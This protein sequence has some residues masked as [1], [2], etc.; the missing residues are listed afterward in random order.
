MIAKL[1]PLLFFFILT[2]LSFIGYGQDFNLGRDW[3]SMGPNE[4]PEGRISA[5]GIGP[6][7]FIRISTLSPNKMLAGSLMGGLFIS[8]NGGDDWRNSGSD[9]WLSSGCAWAEFHPKNSNIWFAVSIRDDANGAP[10]SIGKNGGVMRTRDN[11]VTWEKVANYHDFDKGSYVTIYGLRFH[12][13][14]VN[15]LYVHTSDGLYFTE[16]CT[17]DD[18]AWTKVNYLEGSIYD[19]AVSPKYICFSIARKNIWQVIVSDEQVLTQIPEISQETRAINGITIERDHE[20]FYLLINFKSGKDEIWRY[21]ATLKEVTVVCKNAAVSFGAGYTFA[22]NPFDTNELLFGYG[23]RIRKWLIKEGEFKHVSSNYHV[24]VEHIVYHPVQKDRLFIGTHGGVFE[25]TDNGENWQFKSIGIGNAEVYGLAVATDDPNQIA[26]GLNHDGSVV[27]ADW[28]KNGI[29]SWRQVNGGDALIPLINPNASHIIYTSNQYAGGGAYYSEDTAKKNIKIHDSNFFKTAGWKMALAL[30]P[31]K[32]SILFFNFEQNSGL[33]KGNI[34]IAMTNNPKEPNERM[35]I[36]NFGLT[37]HLGSYQVYG[38]FTSIYHPEMLLAHVLVFEKNKAGKPVTNHKL[39]FINNTTAAPKEIIQSWQELNLPRNTWVGDIVLDPKKWNKM[40]VSYAH[41][42]SANKNKPDEKG[43]IYFTT[44]N[45]NS[46]KQNK[47]WDISGVITSGR[48]GR[49]NMVMLT[50][51]KR[52]VFLGTKSGVY[53]GSK[54]TLRGG[55]AWQKVGYGLPHCKIVGLDF[56]AKNNIL[57]V[58]TDG[59]GVWQINIAD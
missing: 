37:H 12:P 39:F 3:Q 1:N 35:A 10:G 21:D 59:R 26:I 44:F 50:T 54:S 42:I 22:I 17:A 25:S 18:I 43:M 6:V 51:N 32:D 36:S 48:G 7:E 47:V 13:V 20:I 5:A 57:T 29:Y 8:E 16:D 24:D 53:M 9:G 4:R 19:L 11:G 55:K 58:G 45:K 40:Y 28:A 27:R 52:T 56:N 34:D 14:E 23:V 31:V 2:L 49:Y 15:K 33:S 46:L 30:H 41:G 38:L